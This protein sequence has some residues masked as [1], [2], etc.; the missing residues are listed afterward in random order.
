MDE[1][2]EVKRARS[3]SATSRAGDRHD[4]IVTTLKEGTNHGSLPRRLRRRDAQ[5][6]HEPASWTRSSRPA[7][8]GDSTAASS[9]PRSR[10]SR[11]R[12]PRCT[13]NVFKTRADPFAAHQTSSRLPG[14]HGPR[15][16]RHEHA[17]T[18]QGAHRPA[19]RLHGQGLRPRR[20]VGP[21]TSARREAEGVTAGD[22]LASAT[23]RSR[24]PR[25]ALPAPVMAFAMR[26]RA[27]GQGLHLIAPAAGETDDR[28]APRPRRPA[29]RSSRAVADARRG[30]RRPPEGALRPE[31]TLKPRGCPTRR[32]SQAGQGPRRHKK[33][34]GG[35]GQFGR[36]PHRDRPARPR[37][38]L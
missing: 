14:H 18:R 38:G 33:Q 20:G 12:T 31:V 22:W 26:L 13:P 2:C 11:A 17:H 21:G 4:E 15:H 37:G 27:T 24:C 10:S 34:S 23:S 36:L 19:A 28:P 6:R 5:P 32:R 9:C 7:F 16:A 25:S 3:W 8:A 29:T 35:R 30:H 1:I